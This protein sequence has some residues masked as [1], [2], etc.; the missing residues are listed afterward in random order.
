MKLV[1]SG[2]INGEST[3]LEIDDQRTRLITGATTV[4]A[5]HQGAQALYI[6]RGV[7][8]GWV[9]IGLVLFVFGA[10]HT[11]NDGNVWLCFC[12]E[13]AGL[14]A[15]LFGGLNKIHTLVLVH[16][17][18]RHVFSFEP[19]ELPSI[20]NSIE[21]VQQSH[22]HVTSE[23]SLT[24]SILSQL[25]TLTLSRSALL[26]S[27]GEISLRMTPEEQRGYIKTVRRHAAW[28]LTWVLVLPLIASGLVAVSLFSSP[29]TQ[30][31]ALF[32]SIGLLL[33]FHGFLMGAGLIF[34]QSLGHRALP[35]IDRR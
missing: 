10:I 32:S 35:W 14:G 12:A 21:E 18:E 7:S 13:L 31:L 22:P 20:Q 15:V 19:R 16:D 25:K 1:I 26:Q 5:P 29:P 9:T 27:G 28:I 3:R 17:Q 30:P 33:I 6:S 34:Q 23:P 24:M 2:E 11:F 8:P 4:S